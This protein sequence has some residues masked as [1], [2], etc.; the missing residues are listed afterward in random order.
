MA[1]IDSNLK[2]IGDN[3]TLRA[4]HQIITVI[5]VPLLL[6][7]SGFGF[8]EFV[9]IKEQISEIATYS[10]RIERIEDW[11]ETQQA[12]ALAHPGFDSRDGRLLR[13]ELTGRIDRVEDR[14]GKVESRIQ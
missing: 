5:G 12:N 11:K 6:L 4:W 8:R 14:L 13:Q 9:I 2:K 10:L 1:D 7:V 3:A